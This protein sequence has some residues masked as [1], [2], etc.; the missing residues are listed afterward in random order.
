[1]GVALAK[2][3]REIKARN[4]ESELSLV[5]KV[6]GII[7]LL[8]MLQVCPCPA[9]EIQHREIAMVSD[10][11]AP[12]WIEKLFLKSHDNERATAS[13]FDQIV[14]LRPSV[15]FI[16]GDVTS[17][18]AK[19]RKW[20]AMDRYL[21]R[22]RESGIPVHALLGNH[23]VMGNARNGESNFLGRFPDFVKTGYY[24]VVD[25][26][27][28]VMLN[29]NFRKMTKQEVEIQQKRYRETLASLDLDPG[30][31]V[32]VVTCHHA[33]YSNSKTVGSS[34]PVQEHF[35]PLFLQ[36]RKC[37]LFI[38]GHAH[39]FEHFNMSGKDF[40]VIGGGGG[41]HQPLGHDLADLQPDYKPLFHFLT[42]TRSAGHLIVNSWQLRNDY[43]GVDKRS[44][45][46]LIV[47]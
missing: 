26:I 32:I 36:T 6:G 23:D 38:T 8:F 25:S 44:V 22:C 29:S 41:L 9:Q 13:I 21:K 27:A 45:V 33:P 28:I 34:I 19:E 47:E 3:F 42:L 7:C 15:L 46:D 2:I 24:Q 39:A 18:G 5:K 12:L 10:T 40:L 20:S 31:K 16:L 14:Q 30:V 11:Q 37:R 43:S 17:W 4:M 1:M 35:V